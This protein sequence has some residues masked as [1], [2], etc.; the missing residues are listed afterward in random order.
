MGDPSADPPDRGQI[1]HREP[2]DLVH[3]FEM[4]EEQVPGFCAHARNPV[5]DGSLQGLGP[6][7]SMITNGPSMGLISNPHEKMEHRMVFLQG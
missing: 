4:P 2:G 5:Q 6:D 3:V 7:F 1:I